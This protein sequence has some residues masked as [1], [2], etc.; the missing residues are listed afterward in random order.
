MNKLKILQV[1]LGRSKRAHDMAY[2]TANEE[3]IDIIVASEPNKNVIKTN[4]IVDTRGD[5]AILLRSK[6]IKIQN[7]I[8][9]PGIITIET[10]YFIL[11]GC[12]ISPN[13]KI[14]AYEEHLKK[15]IDLLQTYQ[16]ESVVL[17]DFNAK[18]TDWG[19]PTTD[20][21]GQLLTELIASRNMIVA[22]NGNKPTFLRGDSTSYID[23][24]FST[25]KIANKIKNWEVLDNE[26]LT[27]H[28]HIKFEI[29]GIREIPRKNTIKNKINIDKIK[30]KEEIS[31][32]IGQ[33]DEAQTSPTECLKVVKK[34]YETVTSKGNRK[35]KTMPYWWSDS[36][37]EQ[38]RKCIE[39]R[40]KYT[41]ANSKHDNGVKQLTWEAY[42]T[43]K[44]GLQKLIEASKSTKWKEICNELETDIWGKGY[45]LAMKQ[46]MKVGPTIKLTKEKELEIIERLFPTRQN[47]WENYNVITNPPKFTNEEIKKAEDNIKS[48]KAPGPDGIPPEVI[49]ILIQVE[50]EYI[51]KVMNGLL[52]KQEFPTMWKVSKL[53]LIPKPGKS[54]LNP[55]AFRPLCLI[56]AIGK[57]YE[58]LIKNRIEDEMEKN[59]KLSP[60]QF[61]FRKG[62]STIQAIKEVIKIALDARN[63]TPKRDWCA[64]ITLDVR[65]AFNSAPWNKIVENLEKHQIPVYLINTIK[66]YLSEREIKTSNGN[67]VKV[68]AGIPQGS[69]LGPVLWNVFYDPVLR[70][71]LGTGVSTIGFADDLALMVTAAQKHQMLNKAN[72]A[73][74][75]IKTWLEENGLRLAPE[76]TECV[77]LSGRKE[78]KN[79]EFQLESNTI[80]PKPAVKY[81]GLMIDSN[82]SFR[83]HV[84]QVVQKAE[85]KTAALTRILPNIQGPSWSKRVLLNAV[86]QSTLLYGAPIWYKVLNIKK[87]KQQLEKVQR[88]TM[89]RIAS[90][91][92]TISTV[93]LQI[94]TGV[95]PIDLLIEE[96][97]FL[98]EIGNGHLV[99]VR[100]RA[101]ER[102]YDLWQERWENNIGKG[103]WTKTL[104]PNIR[105]WIKCS[106]RHIDYH[107]TQF[108][109]GHGFF[110]TYSK[111]MGKAESE[112]CIYCG[113]I[114]TPSHPIFTC[115][116][117]HIERQRIEIKIGAITSPE[118]LMEKMLSTTKYWK[119]GHNFIKSIIYAKEKEERD[120]QRNAQN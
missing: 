23:I 73:L 1:N 21:R 95:I 98:D 106:H 119:E 28:A 26:T 29:N 72:I 19:S 78:R 50:K 97:R 3:K 88:K 5:V 34:A 18:A 80:K 112:N 69:V 93:A 63:R 70:L 86:V 64:L 102:T 100:N 11:H 52:E 37:E 7:I 14:E 81:L 40:R 113:E 56:D 99:D 15:L 87:Y 65:N 43:E 115:P 66:S 45:Q 103:Q 116:R 9:T 61:G 89:L 107:I 62:R 117:W 35:I 120:R 33:L 20:N 25:N 49:K 8:K 53:V 13:I 31:K 17:G 84:N 85:K 41:R 75:T 110:R 16:K 47:E 94:I 58:Y 12:Y 91:Y 4:W 111:R 39:A 38:K 44:K 79:I 67:V 74:R 90:G 83:T 77:I 76:K 92:R 109:S 48:G 10:Q 54:N 27:E 60:N 105:Q 51:L 59:N 22:N 104:I 46:F 32:L 96:R 6:D 101:R 57:L 2:L 108:I 24:T 30:I 68:T 42:K 82:L 55:E 36:I 118:N 114:D 71:N